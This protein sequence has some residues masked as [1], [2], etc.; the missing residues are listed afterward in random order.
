MALQVPLLDATRAREELGWTPRHT[1]GEA[2]LELIEGMHDSAGEP[3]PPLAPDTSG[4]FRAREYV[5][6]VGKEA[7]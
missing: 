4:R 5:T 3:T 7:R 6:G 2:L 1:S